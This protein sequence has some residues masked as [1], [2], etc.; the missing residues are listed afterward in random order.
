MLETATQV[1]LEQRA[2]YQGPERPICHHRPETITRRLTHL[3]WLPRFDL[4]RP[5]QLRRVR[6]LGL[7]LVAGGSPTLGYSALEHFL[8]DLEALRVADSLGNALM[9]Q[10]LDGT[11]SSSLY[12][13][14][15]GYEKFGKEVHA[16][17]VGFSDQDIE[18]VKAFADKIIFN[19]I[20][21]LMRYHD[22][23]R[24][25]KLGLRINPGISYSHF[26]QYFL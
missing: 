12:E 4:T 17:S 15:L 19:S 6:P 23:V 18:E 21:Q 7:G 2:T 3:M 25:M 10:Y 22:A 16:Y 1:I 24:G 8:G 14:R 5:Y 13:A 26:D 9:R 20:S 11:T